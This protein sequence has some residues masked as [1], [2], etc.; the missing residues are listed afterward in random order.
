M[1]LPLQNIDE[2][3][4]KEKHTCFAVAPARLTKGTSFDRVSHKAAFHVVDVDRHKL[5]LTGAYGIE[6]RS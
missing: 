5:L 6:M 4:L 3:I 1:P 2:N